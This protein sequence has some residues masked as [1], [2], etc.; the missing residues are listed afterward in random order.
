M[1]WSIHHIHNA[2]FGK[3]ARKQTGNILKEYA[4][5]KVALIYDKTMAPL[6]FLLEMKGIIESAGIAAVPYEAAEGEPVSSELDKFAAVCRAEGIDGIVALGGGSVMDTAKLAGKILANGGRAVDYLGGYTALNVG[7]EVFSPIVAV[8]TTAGTGSESCWGIMCLNEDNGIKTFTRHPITRAVVDPIYCMDLPPYI[9]AYTGMDALTQCAECLVNTH[10]MPNFMADALA[11]E[12]LALAVKYLPVAVHEPHNEE[13]REK[14]CWAAML[15]G[16]AITL[17]KTSS[18]HAIANQISDTY[19]L[20]HGVGVGCGMAALVRYNVR[21]DPETTRIWAPLFG[22][23]CPENADLTAVG[24]QIAD[25]LDAL[26]KDIGMKS[27]KQLGIPESFCDTIAD[28]VAKDKKWAIVPNPP[29]FALLR[30]CL[31]DS[32]DY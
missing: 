4:C 21:G 17:R 27:M 7:T 16:Y 8:P 18:G 10:A 29:D 2:E 9:T 24:Q 22:I 11:K 31:H 5:K 3:D 12:G 23:D 30:K 1:S 25:Q 26:Q 15:S 19:H 14:M 13:A 28:N 6:G 20:P 32:W